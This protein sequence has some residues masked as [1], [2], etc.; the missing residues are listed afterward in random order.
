MLIFHQTHK[1]LVSRNSFSPPTTVA[2]SALLRLFKDMKSARVLSN[3]CSKWESNPHDVIHREILSLLRLP[4]PPFE[5]DWWL[6]YGK[7]GS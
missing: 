6:P 5:Q 4:V 7:E 1:N 3:K 2:L